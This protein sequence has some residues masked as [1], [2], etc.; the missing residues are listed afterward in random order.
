MARHKLQKGIKKIPGSGRKKGTVNKVTIEIRESFRMLLE[1]N[2][3]QMSEWLQR[4]AAVDPAK[5]LNIMLDLA[6][7]HI[8]KLQRTELTGSVKTEN[9]TDFSNLSFDEL[10]ALRS[11]QNG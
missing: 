7:Y 2:V 11:K 1:S 4:V 3:D 10:I 9:I 8:P 5:A 6:E